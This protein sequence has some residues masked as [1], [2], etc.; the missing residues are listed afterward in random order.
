[1]V[2]YSQ[3]YSPGICILAQPLVQILPH[4]WQRSRYFYPARLVQLHQPNDQ[5][6]WRVDW[7]ARC[8]FEGQGPRLDEHVTVE[9]IVDSLVNDKSRRRQ[10]QVRFILIVDPMLKTLSL[11][12]GIMPPDSVLRSTMSNGVWSQFQM[13]WIP[14]LGSTSR[15]LIGSCMARNQSPGTGVVTFH[16]GHS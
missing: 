15:S 3:S 10:V 1:M 8:H 12:D 5:P 4:E 14:T 13:T 16:A 2:L 7:W 9:F 11:D 6:Q